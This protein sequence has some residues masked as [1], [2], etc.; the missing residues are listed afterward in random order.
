MV[1]DH[2]FYMQLAL[3]EAWKYQAL[4]YPNPAV[5]ALILDPHGKILA[6]EAHHEAGKAHAE[7]N[8]AVQAAIHMGDQ[9]LQY[10]STPQAQYEYLC[11]HY[12]NRFTGSIIYVTLEP[13]MHHGK[14]PPCSLLIQTLGF[15]TVV[16]GTNDPH[17]KASGAKTFLQQSGIEVLHNVLKKPCDALL[18][19][20]QRWQAKQ[21]FI[22]FKLAKF[23]NG[24]ISGKYVSSLESRKLV[25]QLRTKTDLLVIGG[26]TVRTDRPTL[27]TRLV[28]G[29]KAPDILIYTS[30]DDIDRTIPLFSVPGR[31]VY[32]AQDF[33]ILSKYQHIMIEGGEGMFHHT[34]KIVDYYLF[35]TSDKF[36]KGKKIDLGANLKS[37]HCFKS[38]SDTIEWFRNIE[39]EPV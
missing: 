37:L 26:D 27:D 36:Q 32:I 5:G 31:K 13:C 17:S 11:Q 25:H 19:P 24:C 39:K 7:L 15:S 6:I 2:R 23:Q 4:T 38:S 10:I 3:D 16:I 18:Y 29:N 1:I 33:D 12:Q 20:F 9:A 14:T 34:H 8:A 21:N 28:H 35:F 30:H 22:F